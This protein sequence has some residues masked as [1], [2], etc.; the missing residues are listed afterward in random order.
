MNIIRTSIEG[1]LIL[2][3]RV[4][5]DER[6]Y[7]FESYNRHSF[8]SAG[9][10]Y[11]FVQDNQSKSCYGIRCGVCIFNVE[12]T[13]RPNW[14]VSWQ[15]WCWMWPWTSVAVRR[16]TAGTLPWSFRKRI[17][18][19]CSSR[20]VLRTGFLYSARQR[21]FPTSAITCTVASLREAS[22]LTIPLSPLTGAS[23]CT[24]PL[25]RKKTGRILFCSV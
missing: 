23:I 7:F 1:V 9:L 14:Y 4:F 20:V 17:S 16:R 21:Y 10:Y 8:E 22:G 15:V 24:K 18:G 12:S 11:D 3:P 2:E 6:G 5:T 13:H 19:C 25:L